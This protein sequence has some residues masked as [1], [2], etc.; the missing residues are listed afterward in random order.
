MKLN[1]YDP[2]FYICSEEMPFTFRICF[3]MT[4]N[5][6]EAALRYAADMTLR[7]YPHFAMRIVR[8]GEEYLTE[9]NPLPF[10]VYRDD[11]VIY[12]LGSKEVNGHVIAIGYRDREIDLFASH[13]VTDGG[14]IAMLIKTLLYYYLCHYT[15]TVLDPTGIELA[16]SPVYPDEVGNPFPEKLIT[17]AEPLYVKKYEDCF[18][19]RDGGYV[20]DHKQTA[21]R[22]RVP[23]KAMMTFSFDN[24]GSPNA[25]LSV[26]MT[27]AIR[28]VHP[29][30]HKNVVCAISF[31]FR[32]GIGNRHNAGMLSSAI[33]ADYPDSMRNDGVLKMCTCTRGMITL[34]SQPENVLY[35]AKQRKAL[36][37]SLEKLPTLDE[38]C[39]FIGRRALE[40]ANNNT[41]SVSYV[42]KAD[43]GSI[44]PYIESI[45]NVTDGSTYENAFLEVTALNGNFNIALLQGFSSDVYYRALLR[46][47]DICGIPYVEDTPVPFR[48]AD[49]V[50]PE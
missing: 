46:Q 36:V 27:R 44:A 30:V 35:Y 40:D 39:R 45:Y 24:D 34:Q 50:L 29:D 11:K 28:E 32:A 42:G 38:R 26:L 31:N 6:S 47:F 43:M 5:V 1:Y 41:F 49:T 18:R 25:L 8:D 3:K 37:E 12:P 33:F 22:F 21:Y 19:L 20:T 4:E 14:G 9:A 17:D 10:V 23:E 15:G 7:R 2:L 13:C 16:D 48:C